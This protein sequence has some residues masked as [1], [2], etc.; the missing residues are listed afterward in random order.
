M[1]G[2]QARG[3]LSGTSQAVVTRRAL[4]HL[5]PRR[6]WKFA[7]QYPAGVWFGMASISPSCANSD[8]Y[9]SRPRL[10]VW[11][12]VLNETVWHANL[13]TL[14]DT[15]VHQWGMVLGRTYS[16]GSVS[17]TAE[18]TTR[19]G[20]DAVFKLSIPDREARGEAEA[21]Q[22]WNGRNAVRLLNHDAENYALLIERC[23]PGTPLTNS[24]L[25]AEERLTIAAELLTG[26]WGAGVPSASSF[27]RVGDVTAEWADLAQKRMQELKPP[28]NAALVTRGIELLRALPQSASRE[29]IVH[30]D[31]NPRNILASTRAHFSAPF[32]ISERAANHSA[33]SMPRARDQANRRSAGSPTMSATR[34]ARLASISVGLEW[35]KGLSTIPSSGHK[36]YPGSPI[37]GF[38]SM[39]SQV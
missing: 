13:P 29:V 2:D 23:D 9:L 24:P 21:L 8:S 6:E 17:F 38:G 28:Y 35:W 11:N 22:W 1:P 32:P 27:E 36:S 16:G 31:Y 30:G 15:Y 4:A 33:A 20:V 34:L 12:V 3:P 37:M 5:Q 25:P 18:A 19:D 39:I 10:T 14:I 7:F 26:L